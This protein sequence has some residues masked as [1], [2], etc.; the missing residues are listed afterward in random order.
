MSVTFVQLTRHY[1][2]EMQQI[3]FRNDIFPL[4]DKLFRLAFRITLDRAEAEDVVQETLIRVWNKKDEWKQLD[5]VEAFSL[6]ICRNLSIDRSQK[7]E[8]QNVEFNED[9]HDR[10]DSSNA[11]DSME[12]KEKMQIIRR[13]FDNLPEKQRSIMQ[14]RDIEEKRYKEIA[15]ILDI[16]EE[17]VKVNLFRARKSIRQ[18]YIEIENYGL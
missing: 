18:Q 10:V 6:T 5:S 2:R 16:T 3:S 15:E 1:Y 13:L 14:L 11:I 17:Q 9:L 8:A 4:K 7:K 12:H